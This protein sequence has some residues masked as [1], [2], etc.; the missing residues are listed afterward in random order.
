MKILT[1]KQ[2]RELDAYTI[3]HEPITSIDLME[4]ASTMFVNWFTERYP[5]QKR[6]IRIICGMGNNGGDGLAVA[7]L[8]HEKGYP[9]RVNICRFSERGSDDFE[10][11][12]A[13][14]QSIENLEITD[15]Y[16]DHP[17]PE[18]D[19]G[20]ILI[21]A[22]FGSGLNRPVSG[23]WAG[24]LDYINGQASAIISIDIPSGLFADQPSTGTTIHA[25]RTLTFELPKLAFLFPENQDKVGEWEYRS[26]GLSAKFQ[27]ELESTHFFVD[28]SLVR[29]YCHKR[30]K[31]D[32]KGTFG[33]ALLIAGSYGKVGAAILSAKAALRSGLGLLTIHSPRCAYEILQISVPEAMVSI[34]RHRH[35][36]SEWPEPG[37][38]QAIGIGPGIDQKKTTV[39]AILGFIEAAQQPIVIDADGLNILSQNKE[40]IPRLPAS[41]I[42]TPHPKEFERL[43]GK[44]NNSFDRL[45][46][47]RQLAQEHGIIIV[48]KGAHT[49]I[50]LPNGHCYFNS[51]GN[52]GMAT[53][54]S[55]DVLTG[56]I[57]GLLAQQY[58]P[59]QA[60]ILGVYLHGLAGD[61][62]AAELEHHSLIAGDLINYLGKAFMQLCE[63]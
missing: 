3:E 32:H 63:R 29:S 19:P 2:T 55:G 7:R 26:I 10:L 46:L 31:F 38:Y 42:L 17:L 39:D 59:E 33:H 35:F 9:V 27:E 45:A 60:A 14:I 43:F 30:H 20:E 51:T 18:I 44:T 16:P 13:R 24:L 54:G 58:R 53:G 41:S 52:P 62:A 49:C 25:H 5:N 15:I 6:Y 47:Q 4:R 22:I 28:E 61:L 34:D 23:F 37:K 57:T 56:I 8:L 48:L 40:F 50:A 11:N 36:V 12:L 21:D 1:A